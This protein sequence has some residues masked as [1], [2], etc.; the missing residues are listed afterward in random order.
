MHDISKLYLDEFD[1]FVEADSNKTWAAYGTP[2]YIKQ[3]KENK[4]IQLHWERNTHHPEYWQIEP[5]TGCHLADGHLHMPFLDILEMVIDWKS[6]AETYGT[7]FQESINYS[8]E[9]FK[10]NEKQEWLIR[11]IAK[12]L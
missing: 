2:E 5:T 10:F 9:R 3:I 12:D 8:I 1:G 11:L 6:A 7:D 4:G